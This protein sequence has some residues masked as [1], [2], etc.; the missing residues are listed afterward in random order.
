MAFF[1]FKGQRRE[2]EEEGGGGGGGANILNKPV[3]H[4]LFYRVDAVLGHACDHIWPCDAIRAW[5]SANVFHKHKYTR[6]AA[7]QC[8][9]GSVAAC[10]A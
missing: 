9:A 3:H 10:Q 8:G 1:R 6:S 5:C 2:E 4:K 7:E